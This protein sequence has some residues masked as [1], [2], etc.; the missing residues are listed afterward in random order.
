MFTS[1]IPLLALCPLFDLMSFAFILLA[2]EKTINLSITI[3]ILV[4]SVSKNNDEIE[5]YDGY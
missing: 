2:Y 1:C 3:E 4:P 5:A